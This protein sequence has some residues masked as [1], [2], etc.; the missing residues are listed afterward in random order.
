MTRL[1]RFATLALGLAPI[2]VTGCFLKDFTTTVARPQA[3][4]DAAGRPTRRTATTL[5][6]ETV[7]DI[8]IRGG[9][10]VDGSGAPA[11][12][13]DVAIDGIVG[14]RYAPSNCCRGCASAD[15]IS[16]MSRIAGSP[17]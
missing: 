16:P 8:V 7:H 2:G 9:S 15:S 6:G 12:T 14:W 5:R 17:P 11:R 1:G 3:E 13:A 10:V 4:E